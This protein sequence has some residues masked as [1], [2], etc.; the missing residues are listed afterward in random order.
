MSQY[1]R[2]Q[3]FSDWL[4][5]EYDNLYNSDVDTK[6]D[7]IINLLELREIDVDEALEYFEQEVLKELSKGYKRWKIYHKMK[8]V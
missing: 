1:D 8:H 6:V 2:D 3:E 4:D 5:R 7:F